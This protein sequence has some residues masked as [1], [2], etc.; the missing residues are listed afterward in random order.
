MRVAVHETWKRH[1]TSPV[2]ALA[3]PA[4]WN[5]SQDLRGRADREDAVPC[6]GYRGWGVDAQRS[7][8]S[9]R[10]GPYLPG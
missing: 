2:H 10:S 5:L 9:P 6:Y 7:E 8:L 3:A 4:G 1:L